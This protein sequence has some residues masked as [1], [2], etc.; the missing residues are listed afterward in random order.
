M[1]DYHLHSL[2]SGDAQEPMENIC[3]AAQKAGLMH[4]AIT[5]H[6]DEAIEFFHIR[7]TAG[8]MA[9]IARC[10][11]QFPALTIAAG[12]EL[13][14][15]DST[16]PTTGRLPRE[17]GLDFALVSG[18]YVAGEDPYYAAYYE[19]KPQH[20]AYVAYLQELL[21]MVRRID[22]PFVLGHISYISKFAPYDDPMLRY[23]DY[24]DVLDELLR[25][26]V[27]K[28][29]GLEINTSGLKN[30]AGTLPDVD[31]LTRYR[32]LGGEILTV[33][34]DAHSAAQ[35]GYGIAT[36][37]EKARAAGFTHVA[38]YKNLRPIFHAI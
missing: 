22:G 10:Q 13:D 14:Y 6:M 9:D 2:W 37:L 15:H 35:V 17:L 34:S 4:I 20:T 1:F 5:D 18:H 12:M 7:D 26:A 8:Y 3:A 21:A 32:Q 30:R 24:A 36:A 19:N 11:Q 28:G 23:A 38:T 27:Q 33:G 29:L 16:W 25:T 31:V